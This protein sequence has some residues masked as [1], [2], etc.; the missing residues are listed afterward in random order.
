MRR[1]P[2]GYFLPPKSGVELLANIF[3]A[4]GFVYLVWLIYL[5]SLC[6][7]LRLKLSILEGIFVRMHD[8]KLYTVG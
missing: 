7:G 6:C 3:L 1:I 2:F 5:F 8:T 4:F